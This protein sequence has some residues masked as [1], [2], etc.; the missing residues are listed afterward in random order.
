MASTFDDHLANQLLGQ[1]TIF[2]GTEIDDVTAQRVCSQLLILSAEDPRSDIKLY[3][4]SSGGVATAG[5]A[6]RDLIRLIPNQVVT[7]ATGQVAGMGQVLLA[8]G[9][10]GRRYALPSAR[11]VLRQTET[12]EDM[13]RRF[14]A[15]EALERGLVDAIVESLADLRTADKGRRIGL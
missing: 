3:I 4:N 13:D 8:A 10:P 6:V 11:I 7:V 14:T 9:A 5:F 1:R 15:Q 12:P 2:V